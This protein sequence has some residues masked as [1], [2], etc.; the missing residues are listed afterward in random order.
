MKKQNELIKEIRTLKTDLLSCRNTIE[1]LK[2]KVSYYMD[3][4]QKLSKASHQ[5]T[6][7]A[8]EAMRNLEVLMDPGNVAL[9]ESLGP[10]LTEEYRLCYQLSKTELELLQISGWQSIEGTDLKLW[11]REYNRELDD[12]KGTENDEVRKDNIEDPEVPI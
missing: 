9:V 7:M 2:Q 5:D 4:M 10:L 12:S 1:T 6:G 8:K 11:T 3:L